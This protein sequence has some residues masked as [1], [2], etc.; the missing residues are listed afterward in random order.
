MLHRRKLH[1]AHLFGSACTL[2]LLF[3]AQGLVLRLAAIA[4]LMAVAI[5]WRASRRASQSIDILTEAAERIESGESVSSIPIHSGDLSANLARKVEQISERFR[6]EFSHLEK[7]HNHLTTIL[8]SMLEGVL[9]TDER[10]RISTTNP[11]LRSIFNVRT[12]PLG[13]L[14]LEVILNSEIHRGIEAVL[15]ERMNWEAEIR[16][17]EKVLLARFAR[18]EIKDRIIGVVVVFHDITELRRLGNLRKDFVS[19]VSH[20]LKTPLTSIRGY[21]ETLLNE[22]LNPVHRKFVEKISR[23]SDQLSEMIEQLFNLARLE[24]GHRQPAWK[25]ISFEALMKEMQNDFAGELERTGL[26]FHYDNQSGQDYFIAGEAYIRRVFHNLIENALKYTDHGEVKIVLQTADED[27]H[28]S[29]Q[30]TGMGIP[31]EDLGR[32]FE[33]FYRVHKDRSR[34]TG[35]SGIG[36]AIVKHIVQLHGGQV[37]AESEVGKGTTISFT[38]PAVEPETSNRIE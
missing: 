11:A 13:K 22:E 33:R 25:S 17:S 16:V 35:G 10:G 14:V 15:K 18:I 23:N 36:L 30:D 9:V 6:Q 38:L 29:V 7:E 26:G 31:K 8:N 4:A 2:L 19:N 5:A 27:L 1:L 32:I 21:A 24:N 34:A 12:Q 37:W 20:E 28:F 3:F